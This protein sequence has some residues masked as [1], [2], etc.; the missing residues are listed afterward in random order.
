MA[1]QKTTPPR[2]KTHLLEE[3][4]RWRGVGSACWRSGDE[5][6]GCQVVKGVIVPWPKDRGGGELGREVLKIPTGGGGR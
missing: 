2:P 3:N 5:G 1:F 4:K 6:Q